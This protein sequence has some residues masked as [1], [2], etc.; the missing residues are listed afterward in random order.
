MN[1]K[2][3]FTLIE[4]LVVLAIIGT[5]LTLIFI[6]F[7]DS[8]ARARDARRT[9]DMRSFQ[10]ALAIYQIHNAS[11][12]AQ[13]DEQEITGLDTLSQALR[14][15]NLILGVI[16]DPSPLVYQYSYQSTF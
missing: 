15:E 16:Q 7:R 10:D 4:L 2:S 8:R 9:S 14:G 6:S 1:K 12:P 11:Y 13:A 3:G 5:L